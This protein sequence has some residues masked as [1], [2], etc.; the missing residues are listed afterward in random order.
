MKSQSHLLKYFFAFIL[1]G[2]FTACSGAKEPAII[3]VVFLPYLSNAPFFIAQEEGFFE[4]QGLT[5]ELIEMARS[6]E[7]ITAL[8][9]GDVDIVGGSFSAGLLNAIYRGAE[10]KVVADKGSIPSSGCGTTT[11]FASNSFLEA[12]PNKDPKDFDGAKIGANEVGFFG[13]MLSVYLKQGNL[14]FDDIEIFGG[15]IA[16][17]FQ[18]VQGGTLDLMTA[19]EPWTTRALLAGIGDIWVTDVDLIP[20]SSYAMVWYGPNL[21]LEKPDLGNRFMVAYLEGVRQYNEGKTDRNIEIIA[22]YTGLEEALIRDACWTNI[23]PEGKIDISRVLDFQ[24]W[25][26]EQGLVDTIL[27][28]E[29]FWDSRFIDYAVKELEENK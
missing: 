23:D 6:S 1:I 9:Q 16:E 15:T 4:D 20:G 22:K 3:K 14:S 10:I 27:T 25:A 24:N 2:M 11:L 26:F 28:G 17:Q 18:A 21:L 13:Y 7:S 19:A 29:Q 12:H 8:E 5:I